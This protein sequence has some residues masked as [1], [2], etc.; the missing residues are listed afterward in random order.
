MAASSEEEIKEMENEIINGGVNVKLEA[1]MAIGHQRRR[2][3]MAM[4]AAAE[5]K[6]SESSAI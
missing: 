2:G 1:I 6:Q 5:R 4:S 3:V